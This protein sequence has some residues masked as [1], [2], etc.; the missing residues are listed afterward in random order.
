MNHRLSRLAAV[1]VGLVL[2]TTAEPAVTAMAAVSAPE[3]SLAPDA[4][5]S[6]ASART[7]L[8][9]SGARVMLPAASSGMRDGMVMPGTAGG[10]AGSLLTLGAGG[11][12]YE[13]PAAALPYLGRGL[14]PSLF[15]VSDLRKMESGGRLPVQVGYAG[16]VPVLPGLTIA[17]SRSGTAQGYLTVASAREFGAALVR[18]YMVDH[19]KGSYGD[20][21]MFADGVSVS[22]A[23]TRAARAG[24]SRSAPDGTPRAAYPMHALTVKGT[25]LA[26]QP[27][28]GD[29]ALVFNVDNSNLFSD[30]IESVNYFYDGSARFSLPAGHYFALGDFTDLGAGGSAVAERLDVLP[31]FT[32]SRNTTVHLAEQAADS[33]V[34]MVTPRPANVTDTGFELRRVPRIGAVTYEDW[35][36]T[37]TFPLWVS[38][39]STRPSVGG[40]Q[41][42]SDQWL[43]SPAGA[44]R[45]YE[46]VLT[47]QGPDGIVPAQRR[48]VPAGSLATVDTRYYSDVAATG[49][50]EQ[51]PQFPDQYN[52]F[53]LPPGQW[54]DQPRQRTEYLT[55]NAAIA[56]TEAV[57]KFAE[58]SQFGWSGG[59]YQ[60]S[61]PVFRAGQRT[62]EGW[63]AYPLHAGVNVRLAAGSRGPVWASVMPSASRAGNTLRLDVTPFTD[64]QPGHSGYGMT[65]DPLATMSGTYEIDENGTKIAGGDVLPGRSTDIDTQATLRPQA[66][67]VRFELNASRIG[68]DYPLST[69]SRTVWTW[70][71]SHEAGVT[72]PAGWTCQSLQLTRTVTRNCEVQPMMTLRYALA[73]MRLDGAAPAGRQVLD[74]SVGHLQLARA[75]KV[76]GAKVAVSFDG[77]TTWTK[78]AVTGAGGK[79][80]AVFS[81]PAGSYVTL[82]VSAA[83]AAG[84]TVSETITR[85][86]AIAS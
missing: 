82:R 13:I 78:A 81:A 45:P 69:S 71:S 73:R 66:S 65:Y 4:A 37:G 68:A 39:T 23:G 59:Q 80:A 77:G 6:A 9:I 33:E 38:P 25:D 15:E 26:G 3:A 32:V 35:L 41:A 55:G 17:S 44:A 27:D 83:D 58:N 62:T 2:V 43:Y 49:A 29:V 19:A 67:V 7:V 14:D 42:I 79:Y 34:A 63:D 72:L 28:T 24:G 36:E 30:P 57:A 48:V 76:T 46:Y 64:N 74:V 86:Y 8:L 18:Q 61:L 22:L 12:T 54:L 16:H 50:L 70:R 52:D 1:A 10:L 20:D 31:Q 21:G 56:W 60:F 5:P 51:F 40:L 11:R 53:L 47:D 75:A 84:G 85:A